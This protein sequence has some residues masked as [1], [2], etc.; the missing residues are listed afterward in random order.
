MRLSLTGMTISGE[1]SFERFAAA[2][3]APQLWANLNSPCRLGRFSVFAEITMPARD[4]LQS[5]VW[6]GEESGRPIPASPHSD[7]KEVD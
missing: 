4:L 3:S 2:G 6:Q 7:M 1:E 5:P